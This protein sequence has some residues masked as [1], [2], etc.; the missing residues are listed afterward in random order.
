MDL[1]SIAEQTERPYVSRGHLPEY[2]MVQDP[3]SARTGASS[4]TPTIKTPKSI[5]RWPGS[6]AICSPGPEEARDKLVAIGDDGPDNEL[7]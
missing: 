3:L 4:R 6:R 1:P 2:E 7:S 5:R